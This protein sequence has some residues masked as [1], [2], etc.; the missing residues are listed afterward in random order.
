MLLGC[1]MHMEGIKDTHVLALSSRGPR[2]TVAVLLWRRTARQAQNR[3]V[4]WEPTAK[5]VCAWPLQL[6]GVAVTS[7]HRARGSDVMGI[8]LGS[9]PFP[10]ERQAGPDW[11]WGTI[12]CMSALC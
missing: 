3:G 5:A 11:G 12:C 9:P 6:P 8:C 2:K 4:E 1:P 7:G 10:C